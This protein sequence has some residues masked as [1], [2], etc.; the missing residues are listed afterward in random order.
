MKIFL[1]WPLLLASLI[2]ALDGRAD[3]ATSGFNVLF[4]SVDDLNTDLGCYGHAIVKSPNVDRLAARGVRFDRAYCQY[5]LCNPSRSSFL[6]GL[7]PEATRIYDNETNPQAYYKDH[8][9]LAEYFHQHGYYTAASGKIAHHAFPESLN[10]DVY[11]NPKHD[12][13]HGGVGGDF[14]VG[15]SELKDEE[16]ADGKTA[17]NVVG[18]LNENKNKRFFI[19]TG[20]HKPHGPLVAPKKYFDLYPPS[21]IPPLIEPLDHVARIPAPAINPNGKLKGSRERNTSAYYACISFMDAQL[22]LILDAMDRLDL[23]KNTVVIFFSDHGW[24]LGEHGG[25][26]RKPQPSHNFPGK[27]CWIGRFP[28][29]TRRG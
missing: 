25:M 12:G 19:A 5:P 27:K 18:W 8:T 7:R 24:H 26:Y 21:I 13:V 28:P 17:R 11:E 4:I 20:F 14:Q 10:W 23:W 6:T 3:D 15:A 22:G 9:P 1:K 29:A 2:L 16:E